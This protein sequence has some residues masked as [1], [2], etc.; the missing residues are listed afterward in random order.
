MLDWHESLTSPSGEVFRKVWAPVPAAEATELVAAGALV[1]IDS[2]GDGCVGVDWLDSND[3]RA[4]AKRG[5]ALARGDHGELQ[6]WESGSGQ[7]AIFV[8]GGDLRR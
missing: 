1:M 2:C 5:M 8:D 4:V 7:I 6:R 3:R